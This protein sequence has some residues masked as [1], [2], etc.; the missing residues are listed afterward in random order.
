[1]LSV[2]APSYKSNSRGH[3]SL[4]NFGIIT[5][6]SPIKRLERNLSSLIPTASSWA[7]RGNSFWASYFVSFL[8]TINGFLP[9]AL[10]HFQEKS[11]FYLDLIQFHLL[12]WVGYMFLPYGEIIAKFHL[13]WHLYGRIYYPRYPKSGNRG[14]SPNLWFLQMFVTVRIPMGYLALL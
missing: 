5:L 7:K 10:T 3:K 12:V 9:E 13:S 6:T 8:D 14:Q 2:R 11:H 1:M 4:V